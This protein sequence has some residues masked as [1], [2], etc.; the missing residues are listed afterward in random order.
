M[1]RLIMAYTIKKDSVFL[2]EEKRSKFY[3]YAFYVESEKDA[4]QKIKEIK[5]KNAGAKHFCY[6]YVVGVVEQFSK[7]CDD[8]EPSGTAG[9][10]I[11]QTIL[12]NGLTNC[13]IVVVRFFGGV[14]LGKG[15]LLR[16]YTDSA[17]G[18]ILEAQKQVLCVA[19]HCT[20]ICD[21]SG[22]ASFE[23]F[24]NKQKIINLKKKFEGDVVFSFFVK[25]EEL[26]A[27]LT[28]AKVLNY[29]IETLEKIVLKVEG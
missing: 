4:L 7:S 13:L 19:T 16:A 2:L 14:L 25:D 5:Q 3:A 26:D 6:A 20:K 17:S 24:L 15:P 27:F 18:A 11:L 12:K 29:E 10:P 8:G 1:L 21:Y 23:E 22:F 28:N 9:K